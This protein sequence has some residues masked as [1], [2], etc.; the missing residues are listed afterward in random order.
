MGI[1]SYLIADA[2]VGILAQRLVKRLCDCK[3]PHKPTK[4]EKI[5]L[6]LAKD[7]DVT[8]YE[9][10]GCTK[11]N[12]T[13]YKGRIA[14]YEILVLTDTLKNAIADEKPISDIEVIAKE[15]GLKTLKDSS[16]RLIL[17]GITTVSEMD[18]IV[19]EVDVVDDEEGEENG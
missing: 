9:P 4:I 1:E 19:H 10:C 5:K 2:T 7:S 16:I 17:Q 14:V 6:G 8:I 15:E 11:C 12:G 13:G 18:R 3:K